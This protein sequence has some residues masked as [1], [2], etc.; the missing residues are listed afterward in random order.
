MFERRLDW[1]CWSSLRAFFVGLC[2]VEGFD[3]C[4]E[5]LR[6]LGVVD[7]DGSADVS[8]VRV[9]FRWR[10]VVGVSTRASG[11]ELVEGEGWLAPDDGDAGACWLAGLLLPR[12]LLS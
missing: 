7:V 3:C 2:F 11:A 6:V 12:L 10:P 9:R 4:R 8:L 1:A 5:R